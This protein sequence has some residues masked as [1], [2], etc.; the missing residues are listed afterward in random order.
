MPKITI[1]ALRATS[2]N[3]VNEKGERVFATIGNIAKSPVKGGGELINIVDNDLTK[4]LSIGDELFAAMV[5]AN[6]IPGKD[7]IAKLLCYPKPEA[8]PHFELP[9]LTDEQIE[10]EMLQLTTKNPKRVK[11]AKLVSPFELER[12]PRRKEKTRG[13]SK[14]WVDY[15]DE[16]DN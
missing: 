2:L 8:L 10:A 4:S 5:V 7:Q 3:A 16:E 1:V 15:L 9:E 12:R 14:R 13:G 11:K 6:A